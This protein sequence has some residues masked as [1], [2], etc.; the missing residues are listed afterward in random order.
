MHC[1][2]PLLL[3][4]MRKKVVIQSQSWLVWFKALKLVIDKLFEIPKEEMSVET[5]GIKA[6]EK[7]TLFFYFFC[8]SLLTRTSLR[9]HNNTLKMSC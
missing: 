1:L 8:I 9:A 2:V 6:T 5:S 7:A 3:V 4:K